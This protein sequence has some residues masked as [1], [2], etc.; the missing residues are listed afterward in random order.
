V[1]DVAAEMTALSVDELK[2][3]LDPRVLT[4]GGITAGSSG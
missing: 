3:L 2:R 4:Q 1:L